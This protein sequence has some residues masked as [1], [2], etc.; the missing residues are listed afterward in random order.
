LFLDDIPILAKFANTKIPNLEKMAQV[1]KE[2]VPFNF[3]NKDTY[4]EFHE[5][6]CKLLECFYKSLKDFKDFQKSK[7]KKE[8]EAGRIGQSDQEEIVKELQKVVAFRQTFK[9]IV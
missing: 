3:Y 9:R 8:K 5:L 1:A 7:V 4:M 2:M 6:L